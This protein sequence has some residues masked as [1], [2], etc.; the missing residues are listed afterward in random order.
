MYKVSDSKYK[1]QYIIDDLNCRHT[2][3]FSTLK[4]ARKYVQDCIK[5]D[6]TDH[7][8]LELCK[9]KHNPN[10][11]ELK[12]GSKQGINTYSEYIISEDN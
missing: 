1:K 3:T 9:V 6:K 8:S 7:P 10:H 12:V 2:V 11:Y 5:E 4:S